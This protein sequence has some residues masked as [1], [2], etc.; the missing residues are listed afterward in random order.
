MIAVPAVETWLYPAD[1]GLFCEPGGFYIDPHRPVDRAI[2]THGHGDHARSGH[3]AVLA[4]TETVAIMKVRYGPACAGTFQT[5]ALGETLNLNGVSVRLAPAGHILG[6]AQIV[7]EWGGKRAVVSGDYKRASD[8]TCAAFELMRCDVFVTEATFA[9]PVFRHEPA[10]REVQKLLASLRAEPERT[11]LI[12]AYGL[13]KCQ[14]MIALVREAGY[15]APVYLHGA[16]IAL[17]GL[18]E[19]LGIGLGD[20]R[21]VAGENPKA[22]MTGGIVLCPPSALSIRWQF[23]SGCDARLLHDLGPFP[24]VQGPRIHFAIAHSNPI[25]QGSCFSCLCPARCE[26]DAPK[27]AEMGHLISSG[28]LV[29]RFAKQRWTCRSGKCVRRPIRSQRASCRSDTRAFSRGCPVRFRNR[30]GRRAS[31]SDWGSERVICEE[32]ARHGA[33]C[34]LPCVQ[35]LP[36]GCA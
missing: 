34:R 20:L 21:P 25:P 3:G 23:D 13:G 16:M 9:L 5:L 29:R 14:R 31:Y 7:L 24:R 2:I 15:D 28:A 35:P 36:R 27:R 8:P 22:M 10:P 32:R 11:H 12:G 30:G 19:D 4:T 1:A 17:C 33:A 6:S 18:Y 26:P